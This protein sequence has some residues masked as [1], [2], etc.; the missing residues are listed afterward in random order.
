MKIIRAKP[1]SPSPMLAQAKSLKLPLIHA[2]SI[3]QYELP[4][5]FHYEYW[6]TTWFRQDGHRFADQINHQ[7]KK[8]EIYHTSQLDTFSNHYNYRPLSL[9]SNPSLALPR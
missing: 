6:R 1:P 3:T 2:T 5:H 4:Q 7:S 9:Q 8:P